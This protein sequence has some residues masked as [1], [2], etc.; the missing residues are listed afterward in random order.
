[1]FLTLLFFMVRR[2]TGK[3]QPKKETNLFWLIIRAF[4][5]SMS[6]MWAK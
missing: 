4:V 1:M 5:V 2:K 6:K 3:V